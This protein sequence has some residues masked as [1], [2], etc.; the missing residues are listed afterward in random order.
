MTYFTTCITTIICQVRQGM[1]YSMAFFNR[2][3]SSTGNVLLKLQTPG[4]SMHSWRSCYIL[5][6]LQ[7]C[8]MFTS[9]WISM[10]AEI[11]FEIEPRDSF[12][13]KRNSYPDLGLW[14]SLCSEICPFFWEN[15]SFYFIFQTTKIVPF[16][17]L[18]VILT[19][20]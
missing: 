10:V 4:G 15:A 14:L 6:H 7:Y 17:I 3:L 8:L 9:F 5:N 18:V 1:L 16:G 19:V 11:E 20:H 2:L 13:V 12:E